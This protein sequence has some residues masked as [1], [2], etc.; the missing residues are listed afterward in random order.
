M[1]LP[2]LPAYPQPARDESL[3]SW[4]ERIGIF[5]GCNYDHW[6]APLAAQLGTPHLA[7]VLDVDSDPRCRDLFIAW[8]GL[9]PALVPPILND[10]RK[11]ILPPLARL[12]FCPAC[13]DED[14]RSGQQPYIRREWSQW[15]C[16]HCRRHQTF[17]ATRAT[18]LDVFRRI[19][20]WVPLWRT[21]P[22][23]AAAFEQSHEQSTYGETV[24]HTPGR[25]N[26]WSASQWHRLMSQFERIMAV[27]AITAGAQV[28]HRDERAEQALRVAQSA[29]L[30]SVTRLVCEAV[31]TAGERLAVRLTEND[32]RGPTK[33]LPD[34]PAL[35]E[36]RVG[37][38]V[39]AAELLCIWDQTD[40]IH[41]DIAR[42]IRT[43]L[44]DRP[45]A[46]YVVRRPG[47]GSS[48]RKR[49]GR[50]V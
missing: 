44:R 37:M 32:I 42:S 8:T 48:V 6:L 27:D 14:V 12:G 2:I 50:I 11:D 46:E 43:S 34:P 22:C 19:L 20:D 25:A 21:R 18:L 28:R 10:A 49:A 1:K 15:S 45:T 47:S 17:L 9:S 41:E 30:R 16:V 39:I 35:L 36:T 4:A 38:M 3:S 13:W 29:D 31:T 24:W 5:Y 23:W 7:N 40:P 26:S 33:V